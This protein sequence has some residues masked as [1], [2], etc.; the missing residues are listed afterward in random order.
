MSKEKT[1]NSSLSFNELQGKI[2]DFKEKR[3][4][5]NKKTREY[6]DSLSE[7]ENAIIE[8]LKT[9]RDVYKPK[10]DHWNKKVKLLKEKK[11]EYKNLFDNLIEEKKKIEL[12]KGPKDLFLLRRLNVELNF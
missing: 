10:R 9:A 4:I 2:E 12:L 1:Q 5:L 8:L 11:I 7:I 3:D 6:I